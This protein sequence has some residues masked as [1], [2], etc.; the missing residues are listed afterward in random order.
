M[1]VKIYLQ[2]VL[3]QRKEEIP[4]YHYWSMMLDEMV[5]FDEE[6]LAVLDVL[7]RQKK[8]VTKAYNKK[9]KVKTF[10]I[11]DLI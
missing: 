1:S 5:N 10:S 4:S 2:S 7:I 9:V 6:R 11:G 8:R 3:N